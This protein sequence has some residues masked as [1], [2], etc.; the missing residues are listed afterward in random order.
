MKEFLTYCKAEYASS[1]RSACHSCRSLIPKATIRLAK[2]MRST[3]FDGSVPWWFHFDCFFENFEVRK[4][5]C[6]D[7]LH[8]LKWEDQQTLRSKLKPAGAGAKVDGSSSEVPSSLEVQDSIESPRVKKI[9]KQ[10][11]EGE[12]DEDQ[13]ASGCLSED[14]EKMELVKEVDAGA[15]KELQEEEERRTRKLWSFKENL[16]NL[17]KTQLRLLLSHNQGGIEIKGN[18]QWLIDQCAELMT[19][20]VT[21]KCPKC[22]LLY[23]SPSP[24]D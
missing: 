20:G 6:I 23:T 2:M 10:D 1:G 21:P 14:G 8:L 24:R 9:K 12:D 18:K 3:R 19:F 22:C 13:D 11:E 15:S 16:K 5:E 17:K 4:A 7:G